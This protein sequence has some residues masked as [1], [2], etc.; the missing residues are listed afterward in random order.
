MVNEQGVRSAAPARSRNN[1]ITVKRSA[2]SVAVAA[3]LAGAWGIPATALA[4]DSQDPQDSATPI[5]EVIAYGKYRRSLVDAIASKRDSTTIVEALSAEDIGKLPDSSIAESLARLP[6]LAGERRNGRTS[7][8]SVRGFREDYIATT[9]NGR[10]ILGIGD[11]RGVEFDLYPSEIISG[12]LVYK[13]PDAAKTVQGIGGIVDLRTVR[14]LD[15]DPYIVFNANLE[16]NDLASGNPDFDDNGERLALS[17]A[18]S[19]ADDTIGVA[20]AI[21]TT[22]SPSQE[23]Q[24]RGW[25]YPTE[26]TGEAILGGHDSFVRSAT[27]ARDTVSGVLQYQ[28]TDKLSF[29]LDALYIDF[30]DDKVFRGVEEGGAQWGTGNY[31]VTDTDNGL[32]TAGFHDGFTSVIRNDGERTRGELTSAALNVEYNLTESWTL[33]ADVSY[34]DSRKRITN[35]ESYSG[36][37]RSGLAT[38]GAQSARS[39]VMTDTGAVWGAHP[40]IA[41]VDLADFNTVRLAGPQGW[42]GALAPVSQ[43]AT[44][45]LADGSVIGPSNAQDGFVNDPR[46]DEQLLTVKLSAEAAL[47]IGIVSG[48]EFG[49]QY[50]DRQKSKDNQ[51]FYLTAPSFPTDAAIPEQFRLGSTNLDFVGIDGVVAYDSLGLYDS[52]FYIATS[53]GLLETGR[54]G[55]TYTIDEELL[56]L[57]A[58]FDFDAELSGIPVSG[59][60]GLQYI[61]TDQTGSGFGSTTGPDFFVRATPITDGD[62]YSD[63]LPS[64]NVNFEVADDHVIRFAAS[65]TLSRARIDDMRPNNVV[66][67]A[68]NQGQVESLDPVNSAWKGSAGNARLRPLEAN[69][70]DLAWD[71]YFADDGFVS[72]AYFEKDLVNWHREGA[73]IADFS[74]FNI[75][76][77]HQVIDPTDQSVVTPATFLGVVTNREDGLKGD[78]SGI[79]AQVN[80]PFRVLHSSLEG[81]GIVASAAFNDGELDDGSEVPGLSE[82]T[83]QLTAYFERGGFQARVSGTKRDKFQTET[84]GLSLSLV[85]TVDQG[86]ELLDAQISYD[87][88]AAGHDKLAGLTLSLQGQNLT[89]AETIQANASDSRQITQFQTFGANYLLG[90][91][92]KFE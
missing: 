40:T 11:N 92:Y 43:F 16:Q 31:T 78:V 86:A 64:L 14:P 29:T 10:E 46:F 28:P 47:D 21:A 33:G 58:K 62:T 48:A 32:V 7:G 37:G 15:V 68:F 81:F 83:F 20:L 79:E 89:D 56:T 52:G 82:E 61:E 49:L 90:V 84:R 74:Q 80:L 59:N 1:Q 6:G 13:S 67:F 5:E 23:Q 24:F 65:K 3:A 8:I 57:Y 72:I 27:L 17:F 18:N 39:W 38:Q 53:A 35:I 2:V 12:A 91:N 87:F 70:Y 4:Q 73:F 9:L 19:F 76:G 42:G 41:A 25:G 71:W 63:L 88:G 69:Q 44:Q 77:Y 50:S 36:V 30:K 22:E 54:F 45:T 75:P 60:F 55:D 34:G 51:G 66:S 85:Q 26:S